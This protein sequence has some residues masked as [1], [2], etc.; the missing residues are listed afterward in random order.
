MGGT[1]AAFSLRAADG[2]GVRAGDVLP[3]KTQRKKP[4]GSVKAEGLGDGRAHGTA[5]IAKL[6]LTMPPMS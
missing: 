5:A 1:D 6:R 4:G 2:H 3:Q